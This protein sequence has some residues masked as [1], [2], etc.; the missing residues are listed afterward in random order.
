MKD[1]VRKV[2]TYHEVPNEHVNVY[3]EKYLADGDR[4]LQEAMHSIKAIEY[5]PKAMKVV[6]CSTKPTR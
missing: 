3:S 2:T 1:D 6:D 5:K 4:L